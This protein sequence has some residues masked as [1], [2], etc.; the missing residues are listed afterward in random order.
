[1]TGG[2]VDHGGSVPVT[3]EVPPFLIRTQ[4]AIFILWR[5]HA[6]TKLTCKI[7][8]DMVAEIKVFCSPPATDEIQGLPLD[9]AAIQAQYLQPT[10]FSFVISLPHDI[11]VHGDIKVI[12]NSFFKGIMIPVEGQ[13]REIVISE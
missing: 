8:A 5:F 3:L 12:A 2:A 9:A 11:N 6:K 10:E 1:M 4:T 13:Q 7:K